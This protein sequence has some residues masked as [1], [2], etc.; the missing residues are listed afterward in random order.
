MKYHAQYLIYVWIFL[1]FQGIQAS[2]HLWASEVTK[3]STQYNTGTYSAK[4]ILGRPNVY[5]RYGDIGGTWTQA[6]S[7][8][9][10]VH[11]I[12]VKFPKKIFITKVNIYETF[13]AGAVVKISAKDGQ[14]QWVD[15]FNATHAQV[16]RESRKFSPQIK[17]KC[18]RIG[19]YLANIET[20][21]EAMLIKYKLTKMKT[22]ISFFVGG[23][24]INRR[25]PGGDWRWIKH[26][27]MTKIK[28]FAFG[29][30]EPDGK[31]QS[32]QD[33]ML[34]HAGDGYTFHDSECG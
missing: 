17:A 7:E 32:P 12:E 14:N 25:K 1:S 5:P 22:G 26:G 9:D 18:L 13:H 27:S 20:L 3:F 30:C 28:Y 23:R 24:N 31:E 19:G 34:F 8:R 21:E 11:F 15:I 2:I 33:C 4:Q 6:A 10:R 29:K 16:I